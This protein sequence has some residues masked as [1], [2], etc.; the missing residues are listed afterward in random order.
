MPQVVAHNH[1]DLDL[2]GV[3]CRLAHYYLYLQNNYDK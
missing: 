3:F 1:L 2:G